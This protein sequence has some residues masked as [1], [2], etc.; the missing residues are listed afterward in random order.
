MVDDE[1]TTLYSKKNNNELKCKSR[2]RVHIPTPVSVSR[3]ESDRRRKKIF[4]PRGIVIMT[5][6][7]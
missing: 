2:V 5:N 7:Q 3:R 4:P 1:R 6:A